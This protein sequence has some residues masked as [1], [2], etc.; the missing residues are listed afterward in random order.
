MTLTLTSAMAERVL[1]LDGALGTEFYRR[2][3]FINRCYDE[4]VLS[5]PSLVRAVHQDYVD[6]G[7]DLIT[8]NT[9]GANRVRLQAFGLQDRIEDIV[10][11]A[12]SLAKSAAQDR[13]FV[14]GSLGP[15]GATLAPAGRLSPGM[16]YRAFREQIQLLA[17]GGVDGLLLETFTTLAE[18]WHAVRAA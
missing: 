13:A 3:V 7:A 17:Q 16:A 5:Q 6:A 18:L 10:L 14:L 4:L 9:F 15:T 12:C 2:G 1:L 11:G 8:T